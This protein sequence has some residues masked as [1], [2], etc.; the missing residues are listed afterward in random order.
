MALGLLARSRALLAGDRDAEAL[1]TDALGYLALSPS[2]T[3]LAR[4]HLLYGEWL[5][6]RKRRAEARKHL[7]T[8][9]AQFEGMGAAGFAERARLEL[10]AT[11][12]SARKRSPETRND[13]TPQETQIAALASRGATNP[14]IASKLFISPSTVDYHLRKVFRKLDVSS[15]R[16]LARVSLGSF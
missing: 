15:R 13:L 11:G 4:T 9:R 5:R 14:E 6:R 8:A 3:H 10:V 7:R 2:A 1:Y 16:D 12:E